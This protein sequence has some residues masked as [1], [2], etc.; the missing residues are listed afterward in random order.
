MTTDPG[1][2]IR[3]TAVAASAQFGGTER[4]LLDF[5]ARAFEHDINLRVLTPREGPLIPVLNEIGVPAA[6]VPARASLLRGS[7]QVGHLWTAP[8]A[9]L[10]LAGWSRALAAHGFW[11]DA[12]VVYTIAFKAH[13]AAA[14]RRR[15]PVVWHLHEFPPE[16][17]GG[18]WRWLSRRLPDALIANSEATGRAWRVGGSAGRGVEGS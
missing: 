17:T 2:A 16:A 3:V 11:R 5:A 7:Q 18:A 13:L 12:D 9:L 4:V 8:A 15:H 6:V 10:G 1:R 14:L